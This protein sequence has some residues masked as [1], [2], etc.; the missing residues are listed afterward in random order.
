MFQL[1]TP[2]RRRW[3]GILMAALV[4]VASPALAADQSDLNEMKSR[5]KNERAEQ[6]ELKKKMAAA[7]DELEGSRKGLITLSRNLQTNERDLSLLEDKIKNLQAEETSLSEKLQA[8]YGSMGNLILALERIRRMPP[9]TLVLRPGAPLETAQSAILLR[10]ILP[11][12]NQR[13]DQMSGDLRQL[14]AIHAVLEDDRAKAMKTAESLKQQ[15]KDLQGMLDKRETLYKETKSAYADQVAAVNKIAA[16]AQSLEQ[17]V[18][19]IKEQPEDDT[20]SRRLAN[21]KVPGGSW[22]APVKGKVT[23]R[24]GQR[25]EIGAASEGLRI[26][27]RT[28]GLVTAPVS[29]I[30]RYCGPFR[31]YGN[32]VIIEHAGDLH[33]LLAGLSRI[34]ARVGQKISAGEPVGMLPATGADGSPT[35]YY[36]LRH[37]GRPVDPS[38]KFPDLS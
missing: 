12:V 35:L 22:A 1:S 34:D 21:F 15:K 17:L 19:K 37:N 32:M 6:S 24:F 18:K 9:E 4:A 11:A 3:N 20:P 30:V 25:D 23:V 31:N 10:S 7:E 27:G 38:S 36:E 14:N 33:S 28:G 26:T 29:G 16:E 8:D 2:L 13:A 5:L